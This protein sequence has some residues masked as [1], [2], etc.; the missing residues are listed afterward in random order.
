MHDLLKYIIGTIIILSLFSYLYRTKGAIAT[1]RVIRLFSGIAS[2]LFL[3]ISL[4]LAL[5]LF[6]SKNALSRNE[7][8]ICSI[9]L[10]FTLILGV[11]FVV[12]TISKKYSNMWAKEFDFP[13]TKDK[14]VNVKQKTEKI[15]II[16]WIAAVLSGIQAFKTYSLSA[17]VLALF[18]FFT[19]FVLKIKRGKW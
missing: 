3:A 17:F 19:I 11:S 4:G 9:F 1:S 2:I 12:V 5:Y 8:L 18:L 7:I 6:L 16:L 13:E 14:N 10:L 15:E